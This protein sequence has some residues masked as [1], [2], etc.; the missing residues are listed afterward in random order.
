MTA[1]DE[2]QSPCC[3]HHGIVEEPDLAIFMRKAALHI[4]YEIIQMKHEI[5]HSWMLLHRT[6]RARQPT[7]MVTSVL[8][9]ELLKESHIAIDNCNS[10]ANVQLVPCTDVPLAALGTKVNTYTDEGFAR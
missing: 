10:R 9:I 1:P 4:T 5:F 6:M 8:Y 2:Q 3:S 7:A